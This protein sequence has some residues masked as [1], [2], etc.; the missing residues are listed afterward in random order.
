MN[1][2]GATQLERS[3]GMKTKA[4]MLRIDREEDMNIS[5]AISYSRSFVFEPFGQQDVVD[6]STAVYMCTALCLFCMTWIFFSA[7]QTSLRRFSSV[8]ANEV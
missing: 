2:R 8:M 6:C 7:E 4:K 5:R 3:V 1:V